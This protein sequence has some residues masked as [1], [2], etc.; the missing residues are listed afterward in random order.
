MITHNTL[1]Y[2]AC[3]LSR[4]RNHGKHRVCPLEADVW[5]SSG[6]G[7]QNTKGHNDFILVRASEP[8]VQQ[9]SDLMLG[10]PNRESLAGNRLVLSYRSSEF[11]PQQ[12]RNRPFSSWGGFR[13]GRDPFYREPWLPLYL[14]RSWC[15]SQFGSS[16][17]SMHFFLVLGA[18]VCCCDV[19]LPQPPPDS[20]ANVL[21]LDRGDLSSVAWPPSDKPFRGF[22]GLQE[23]PVWRG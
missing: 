20:V 13:L 14:R 7:T 2:L 18:W 3:Q 21:V 23:G 4:F 10:M 6:S 17:W 9:Y 15:T 11:F 22:L 5:F 16:L 8:Y 19:A 12:L 1:L